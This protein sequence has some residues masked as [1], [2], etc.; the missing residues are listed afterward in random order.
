MDENNVSEVDRFFGRFATLMHGKIMGQNGERVFFCILLS[1][2][3][4]CKEG[5]DLFFAKEKLTS[6][7]R[8]N[9]VG[10]RNFRVKN[11]EMEK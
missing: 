7:A 3:Q 6:D 1:D 2:E 4:A 5:T 11:E 8:V 10:G 9:I